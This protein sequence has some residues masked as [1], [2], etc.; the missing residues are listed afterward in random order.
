MVVTT[1]T[2]AQVALADP[3]GFWELHDGV[4]RGKPAMAYGH[5][6]A[7]RVLSH[8]LMVQLGRATYQVSVNAS[9]VRQTEA[10][11]SIPDLAVIPV[12]SMARYREQRREL[13]VYDEPLPLVVEIWSP[14]TGDYDIETKLP[15]Y[16]RRG[17]REIWRVH[18]FDRTVTVWRRQDDGAYDVAVYRGGTIELAAL[19]GVRIDLDALFDG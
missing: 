19:P 5:N 17:D 8:D 10:N 16:Q 14:S 13:E 12:A 2:Y 3:D 15:T 4:L 1:R 18:P 9:R 6:F 11:Y 7:M